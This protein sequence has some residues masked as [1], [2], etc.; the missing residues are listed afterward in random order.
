MS[1]NFSSDAEEKVVS[2]RLASVSLQAQVII[3]IQFYKNKNNLIN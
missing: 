1:Q 3:Y 2:V